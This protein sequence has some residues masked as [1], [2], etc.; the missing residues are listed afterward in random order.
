M[1]RANG[2]PGGRVDRQPCQ[3]AR[4]PE[5]RSVKKQF[6]ISAGKAL[7]GFALTDCAPIT[8]DFIEHTVNWRGGSLATHAGKAVRLKFGLDDAD[9]FAYKFVT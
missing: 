6:P 4:G 1:L 8:G 5:A 3:L 2:V 9:V 7:P